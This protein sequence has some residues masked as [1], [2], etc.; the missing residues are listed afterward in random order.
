M[1]GRLVRLRAR[2]LVG[3]EGDN[4]LVDPSE[5]AVQKGRSTS[6]SAMLWIF[7]EP[8][9]ERQ[10]CKPAFDASFGKRDAGPVFTFT[11]YFHFAPNEKS[12]SKSVFDPGPL[13][14]SATALS[15]N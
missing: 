4:F 15:L 11:G 5:S 12:R 10:V 6:E 8:R 2:V 13:Q 7:C 14:F 1:D 3:W 9:Y